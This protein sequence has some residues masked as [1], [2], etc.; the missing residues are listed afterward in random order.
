MITGT[1][2]MSQAHVAGVRSGYKIKGHIL[3]SGI[4][5]ARCI[6]CEFRIFRM[7]GSNFI[8]NLHYLTPDMNIL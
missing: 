5:A 3:L 2:E 1:M 4:C 6:L 7:F 8:P